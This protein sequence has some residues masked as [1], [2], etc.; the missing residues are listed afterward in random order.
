MHG[1]EALDVRVEG[2]RENRDE[3]G[4]GAAHGVG[5]GVAARCEETPKRTIG[6]RPSFPAER[7]PRADFPVAYLPPARLKA[8]RAFSASAADFSTASTYISR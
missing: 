5:A 7:R 8:A 1:G 6:G 4:G 3:D 2:V